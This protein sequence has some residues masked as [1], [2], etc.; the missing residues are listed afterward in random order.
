MKTVEYATLCRDWV[1]RLTGRHML[2]EGGYA[3]AYKII[4]MM[5]PP[6]FV[7]LTNFSG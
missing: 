4:L 1:S 7:A 6:L 5:E 3:R 2:M